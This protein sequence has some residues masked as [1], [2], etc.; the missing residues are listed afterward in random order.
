MSL[1]S[2]LLKYCVAQKT[3]PSSSGLYFVFPNILLNRSLFNE[4]QYLSIKLNSTCLNV[5]MH[6]KFGTNEMV[7]HTIASSDVQV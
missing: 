1:E 5:C 7:H 3:F 6:Y 2:L 4:D